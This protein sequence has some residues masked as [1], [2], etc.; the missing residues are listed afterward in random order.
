MFAPFPPPNIEPEGGAVFA[1]VKPPLP[2][3]SA[4][5]CTNIGMS[6]LPVP[7]SSSYRHRLRGP[8]DPAPGLVSSLLLSSD[9]LLP[10][11]TPLSSPIL[12]RSLLGGSGNGGKTVALDHCWLVDA[13]KKPEHRVRVCLCSKYLFSRPPAFITI[14]TSPEALNQGNSFWGTYKV[15]PA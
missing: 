3:F 5:F 13:S 12:A 9:V 11:L 14:S 10:I 7:G 2:L 15:P 6:S 1:L 4:S 8:G